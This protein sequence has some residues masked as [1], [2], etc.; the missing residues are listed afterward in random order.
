MAL[1]KR[2]AWGHSEEVWMTLIQAQILGQ[3]LNL[4][5]MPILPS[6]WVIFKCVCMASIYSIE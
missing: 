5:K 4:Y 1:P 6:S 3:L 2:T